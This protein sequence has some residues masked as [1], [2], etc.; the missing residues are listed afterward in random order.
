LVQATDGNFYG[1]TSSGG[2]TDCADGCGTIFKI[3]PSGSLTTLYRF[4]TQGNC[5]DGYNPWGIIQARD[6]NFYG[7]TGHGGASDIGCGGLGCG[8]IFKITPS[9]SLTTLYR[10]CFQTGCPDGELPNGQLVQANDGNFYGTTY[11]GGAN[12]MND[13]AEFGCGTVFKI[14]PSGTLTT[15]YSF[16]SETNCADG[17]EPNAALVQAPDGNF[18]GTTYA[19]GTSTY[20][21]YGC[22]SIFKVTS[23]GTLATIYS[24]C[25]RRGCSDGFL[26][27]AGLLQAPNDTFYGTTLEGGTS[28]YGTIFRLVLPRECTVCPNVEL[29]GQNPHG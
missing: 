16:C 7:A 19:G 3:T 8:T 13:C 25:S 18:Y 27:D 1:T 10:F 20:C 28:N 12:H 14:T 22:G 17:W 4:C 23:S 26:P 24:F 6:G 9:G 15:L 5:T 2:G 29:S 21:D 11:E